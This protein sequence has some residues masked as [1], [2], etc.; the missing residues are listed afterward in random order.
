MSLTFFR[1]NHTTVRFNSPKTVSL[2]RHKSQKPDSA[3]GAPTKRYKYWGAERI[4]GGGG[5]IRIGGP[6]ANPKAYKST[7]LVGTDIFRPVSESLKIS[8]LCSSGPTPNRCF[9]SDPDHVYIVCGK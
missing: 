1:T 7:S 4:I 6:M 3:S 5:E 8:R 2:S 9:G